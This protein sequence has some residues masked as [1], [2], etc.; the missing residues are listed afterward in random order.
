MARGRTVV[1]PPYRDTDLERSTRASEQAIL[2]DLR[3]MGLQWEKGSTPRL[4][5]PY[6]QTERMQSYVDHTNRLL[7]EGKATTVSVPPRRSKRTAR[8][9]SRRDCRRIR[10]TCRNIPADEAKRRKES[11]EAAVVRLRVPKD[12]TSLQRRRSRRSHVSHRCDRDP[13]LVRSMAFPPTTSPSSLTRRD[14]GDTLI[15]GE[16]HISNTPRQICSTRPTGISRRRS[17]TSRW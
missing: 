7:A 11:G 1:Y 14:E 12:A 2:E 9:S 13:V 3:W 6:R 5:R 17:R 4:I 16:D 10:R 8:R 15:R